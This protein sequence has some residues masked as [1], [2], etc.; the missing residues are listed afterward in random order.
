MGI[1]ASLEKP[2]T[3]TLPLGAWS[4]VCEPVSYYSLNLLHLLRKNLKLN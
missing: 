2:A 4:L 1:L 3:K